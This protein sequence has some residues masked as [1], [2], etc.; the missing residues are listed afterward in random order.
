MNPKHAEFLKREAKGQAL[1]KAANDAYL[2]YMTS[3]EGPDGPL[4]RKFDRAY[5]KLQRFRERNS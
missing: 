4:K 2:D 5:T 1:M 3:S